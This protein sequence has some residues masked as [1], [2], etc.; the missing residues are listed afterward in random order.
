M[1]LG[2][3][4]ACLYPME[5]EKAVRF[6]CESGVAEIEIFF[7]SA[8]EIEGEIFKEIK[9]LIES[10]YK[11]VKLI[12]LSPSPA[13]IPKIQG[14]YR[15]RMIIKCKNNAKFREMLKSALKIKLSGDTAV[16]VDI[17]PETVI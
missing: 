5:T 12:I 9:R 14:R 3:S 16:W 4:S 1:K 11:D 17:N 8:C 6:L 10:E 15:F 7:N 2:I 13:S